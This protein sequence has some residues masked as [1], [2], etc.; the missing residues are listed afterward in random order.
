MDV[1]GRTAYLAERQAREQAEQALDRLRDALVPTCCHVTGMHNPTHW[2]KDRTVC[3]IQK[4]AAFD[5][6]F[7]AVYGRD[8]TA[9]D[10]VSHLEC[11]WC[12]RS[13]LSPQD[14]QP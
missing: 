7:K 14:G 5:E 2:T 4:A 11:Y 6:A 3:T 12:N 13:A 9:D 10:C 8:V 1:V